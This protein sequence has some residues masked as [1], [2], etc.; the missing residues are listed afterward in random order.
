MVRIGGNVAR[1]GPQ[2]FK[3]GLT[4]YQVVQEAGEHVLGIGSI[5]RV[6]LFRAGEKR[7][8]DLGTPEG[9]NVPVLANET[10]KVPGKSLPGI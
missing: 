1:P 9:R 10:I 4:V 7:V 2:S 3:E 5:R 8:I 6:N